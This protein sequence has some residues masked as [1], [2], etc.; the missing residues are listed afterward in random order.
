MSS[1]ILRKVAALVLCSM[2][3]TA[4]GTGQSSEHQEGGMTTTRDAD[5][6]TTLRGRPSFE[7]A[8]LQY[9]AA[10]RN[11]ANQLALLRPGLTWQVKEDSWGG[12]TGEYAN[13]PGIHVYLY[14]VFDG[15]IPDTSW[16]QAVD[17]L[18]RGAAALG[19]T[20]M[21]VLIDKPGDHDVTFGGPDGNAFEFGTKA[22]A[23]LSATSDCRLRQADLPAPSP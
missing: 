7:E 20:D 9:R 2:A 21:T 3:M 17:V 8:Q 5:P 12:C 13:T 19:A 14:V 10:V 18:K 23:V 16:P 1:S 15:P 11:W 4:C 6:E 22:A